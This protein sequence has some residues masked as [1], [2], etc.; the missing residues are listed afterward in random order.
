M[1]EEFE[2]MLYNAVTNDYGFEHLT[3]DERIVI[4]NLLLDEPVSY[5]LVEN[6]LNEMGFVSVDQLKLMVF[7]A[8]LRQQYTVE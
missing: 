3:E 7:D 5:S 1:N 8:L 2:S 4:F 6:V